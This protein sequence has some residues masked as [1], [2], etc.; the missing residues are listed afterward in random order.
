MIYQHVIGYELLICTEDYY[1]NVRSERYDVKIITV[2]NNIRWLCCNLNC[3]LVLTEENQERECIQTFVLMWTVAHFYGAGFGCLFVLLKGVV[4][5]VPIVQV[6]LYSM[7]CWPSMSPSSVKPPHPLIKWMNPGLLT[8]RRHLDDEV[9]ETHHV[10]K[11]GPN[12]ISTDIIT[13]F[14][15]VYLFLRLRRYYYL[16][17]FAS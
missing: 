5:N 6:C 14:V 3:L 17:H 10:V 9:S 1:P 2:I 8:L 4:L 7:V 11:L 15:S 16:Q 13:F 12:W